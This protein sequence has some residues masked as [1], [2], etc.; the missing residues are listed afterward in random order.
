MG[1]Y[2][3]SYDMFGVPITL[4]YKGSDTYQTMAGGLISIISYCA[5]FAYALLQFKYMHFKED[6]SLIQ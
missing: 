5:L 6:W 4:N 2:I 1:D 3:R